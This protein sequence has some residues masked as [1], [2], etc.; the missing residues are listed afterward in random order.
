MGQYLRVLR[1]LRGY[2]LL[3]TAALLASLLFAALDTFSF[4]M[5][6]P[7]L[8][9]LF[10]GGAVDFFGVGPQVGWLLQNTLGRII[11]PDATPMEALTMLSVAVFTVFMLKN[12]FDYLQHYFVAMLEQSI[13]RDLRNEVYGHMLELDLRFY[14][15]TRTG[16][17]LTRLTSDVDLMRTLVTKN[18]AT[19]VTSLLQIIATVVILVL[20]SWQ[21]TLLA[22]VVMPL[23]FGIWRKLLAPLR[24]GDRRV[25]ELGGEVTSHLQETVSG[26]RQVKAAAAE[27]FERGRFRDLTQSYFKA[28]VRTERVRALASPL[29]ETMG[30]LGT[31]LLL[32]YGG[33]MVLVDGTI[34]ADGF[35]LFL[36]LSM[37]LYQPAKWIS[38]FP[39]IVQ[40]GL[41][42]ADR[43]FEFL[44]TPIE[45]VD[46]PGLCGFDGLGQEL[47]F[48]NVGFAYS[49]DAQVLHD[50]TFTARAGTVTALVGPSGGGKSTLVD[51]VA[52]FYDPTEGRIVADGVDLREISPR[53]LRQRL[54]IVTQETVLFHDT[55]RA[56]IAYALPNATDAEVEAAARAANAHDF[57]LE[58]PEGYETRLGERGT[59]LSGGQRQRIAIARAILRDPPILIFDEATSALDSE[60]ERLVQEA[61]EHLLE[62]R[63]VFVIAHRLSTIRH[64]DQVLVLENGRIVQQG[65]HDELVDEGGLYRRLYR[66]QFPA[67]GA[68]RNGG[69]SA[70]GRSETDARRAVD[71]DEIGEPA[72]AA[73]VHGS[74]PVDA[75]A[76]AGRGRSTAAGSGR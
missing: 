11:G 44:D 74:D 73:D 33:R 51:L 72:D 34:A 12:V 46:A 25:L 59:R 24:R 30:A 18:V 58:L 4:V 75:A 69:E 54:G 63:T 50:V 2:R 66:L 27:R 5:I 6:A 29:S 37:K 22:L 61:I 52:R 53:A 8:G 65:R 64:A 26:V 20:V 41:A 40:P 28:V 56:N 43:V 47:R 15:R 48:E 17:I 55:V 36:G 71:S 76:E 38:K 14:G 45:M 7:F 13:T 21:L 16:Q 19:L 23:T 68:S 60:S 35:I 39:S 62:G 42:A 31:V 32:W 67:T 10:S 49:A 1:Y 70:V 9:T 57:I 3:L